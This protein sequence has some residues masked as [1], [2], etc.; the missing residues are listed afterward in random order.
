MRSATAGLERRLSTTVHLIIPGPDGTSSAKAGE[1]DSM[2][3]A[4][5]VNA[6]G[7]RI[8]MIMP[9]V[10]AVAST[11]LTPGTRMTP[12]RHV[13]SREQGGKIGAVSG[14]RAV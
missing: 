7:G 12:D 9:A 1:L 2:H 4:A 10:R 8:F 3:A 5:N 6:E 13:G 11:V 14:A